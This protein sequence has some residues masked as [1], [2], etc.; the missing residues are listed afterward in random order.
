MKSYKIKI[1]PEA[2]ADIQELAHW[3]ESVQT[4]LGKRFLKTTVSQINSLSRNPQIYAIRYHEIRC[5]IV[6]KFACMV[7]FY[8]HTEQKAVEVLAVISTYRN[9]DLWKVKT[10]KWK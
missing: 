4:G 10:D 7:H 8:I 1:D 6:R 9:P 2:L 5:M 3:Y